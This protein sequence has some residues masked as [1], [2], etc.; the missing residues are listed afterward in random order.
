MHDFAERRNI[1][2]KTGD[3]DVIRQTFQTANVTLPSGVLS[4]WAFVY[5]A[6]KFIADRQGLSDHCPNEYQAYS[7]ESMLARA[8]CWLPINRIKLIPH[9][10]SFEHKGITYNVP[11]IMYAD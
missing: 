4:P 1:A 11:E 10:H 8:D 9:L 5:A 3:M 7:W 2:Y 6:I